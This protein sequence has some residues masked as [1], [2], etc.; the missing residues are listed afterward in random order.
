[1]NDSTP[2][3]AVEGG[4]VVP[5]RSRLQGLVL[6]PRHEEGRCEGFPLNMTN[7]AEG[8][9]EG[10]GEPDFEPSDS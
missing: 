6:H 5:D 7:N 9:S 4:N 3:L 2:R 1:M 10:E 8:V